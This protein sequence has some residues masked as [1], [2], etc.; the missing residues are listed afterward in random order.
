MGGQGRDGG[1]MSTKTR[2]VLRPRRGVERRVLVGYDPR[3]RQGTDIGAIRRI[4]RRSYLPV[5]PHGRGLPARPRIADAVDA[6][7]AARSTPGPA[8]I[9]AFDPERHILLRDQAHKRRIHT[10]AEFD[11]YLAAVSAEQYLPGEPTR[12]RMFRV[13]IPGWP[14]VPRSPLALVFSLGGDGGG[15]WWDRMRWTGVHWAVERGPWTERATSAIAR[16][17]VPNTDMPDRL[18]YMWQSPVFEPSRHI[19]ARAWCTANDVDI[20][21]FYGFVDELDSERPG[22]GFIEETVNPYMLEERARRGSYGPTCRC[23]VREHLAEFEAGLLDGRRSTMPSIPEWPG[24]DW[25]AAP[26]DWRAKHASL[27]TGVT[28]TEE[29]R[30]EPEDTSYIAQGAVFYEPGVVVKA[31]KIAL[32]RDVRL[33]S[34][35]TTDATIAGIGRDALVEFMSR[36]ETSKRSYVRDVGGRQFDCDDFAV[37]MRA[38]LS[39]HGMNSCGIVAGDAHAWVC[40]VVAGADGPEIVFV[41]PQTDA[42]VERLEGSYSVKRRCEVYL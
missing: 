28:N 4:A 30:P 40:F 6:L 19:R 22:H 16:R 39:R 38:S 7:L 1:L 5:T 8:P 24:W 35:T 27:P 36:D 3:S 20:V 34:G 11:E 37:M 26:D 17:M 9:V 18:A 14:G 13:R 32:G 23:I 29:R 12:M 31:L 25:G 2:Y 42:R 33:F 15:V 21:A 10:D 41:E